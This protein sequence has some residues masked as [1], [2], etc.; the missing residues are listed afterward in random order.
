MFPKLSG[1]VPLR[2]LFDRSLQKN[3]PQLGEGGT[4]RNTGKSWMHRA[5]VGLFSPVCSENQS[6]SITFLTCKQNA[7]KRRGLGFT[8]KFSK[9]NKAV[10]SLTDIAA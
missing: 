3:S 7:R 5:H 1:M 6:K 2:L 9:H 8:V 4:V 10:R